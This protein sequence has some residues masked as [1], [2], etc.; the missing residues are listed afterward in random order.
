MA[1]RFL[2]RIC[3]LAIVLGIGLNAS[4]FAQTQKYGDPHQKNY[5]WQKGQ[6]P[7]DEEDQ[8]QQDQGGYQA[9][10]PTGAM[11]G[12]TRE[13][14]LSTG[15]IELPAIRLR[16]PRF[17]LP[18]LSMFM[19][20][21]RMHTERGIA[22]MVQQVQN[23]ISVPTGATPPTTSEGQTAPNGKKAPM[24]K[25]PYQHSGIV[26]G[27]TTEAV[28]LARV[29][30]EMV[31]FENRLDNKLVVLTAAIQKLATEKDREIEQQRPYALSYSLTPLSLVDDLEQSPVRHSNYVAARR[32]TPTSSVHHDLRR[33]PATTPESM[34]SVLNTSAPRMLRMPAPGA[35]SPFYRRRG[36]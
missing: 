24:Q 6:P 21:P 32:I 5:P 34:P 33:L 3:V 11:E 29:R 26:Q 13:F 18:S 22:L 16:L 4:S 23:Q 15:E 1:T 9:P 36:E 14:G 35:S 20:P 8:E 17:R 19:T 12:A 7:L 30:G 28:E 27:S 25:G 10:P 2:I 31:E